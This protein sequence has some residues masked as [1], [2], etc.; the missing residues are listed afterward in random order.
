[1]PPDLFRGSD[2]HQGEGDWGLP[3]AIVTSQGSGFCRMN[4]VGEEAD[5]S[6]S[7]CLQGGSDLPAY[8][9]PKL[10]H[11]RCQ[12]LERNCPTERFAAD[13][14]LWSFIVVPPATCRITPKEKLC[15]APVPNACLQHLRFGC[16]E[17]TK[18]EKTGE[19]LLYP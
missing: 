12:S 19:F 7:L 8:G 3:Q 16:Y 4:W 15:D 1:M 6:P 14:E 2:G 10:P 9:E 18:G 11:G 13:S 5:F 17:H